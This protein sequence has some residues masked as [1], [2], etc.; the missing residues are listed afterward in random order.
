M[1]E[2][3]QNDNLRIWRKVCETDPKYLK[4][5]N[6]RGGFSAIC[7]QSQIKRA[8]E[9]WGPIGGWWGISDQKIVVVDGIVIYTASLFF[10]KVEVA[11]S[12]VEDTPDPVTFC[13]LPIASDHVFK[14]N[15]DSVKK[16]R[17][18]ALTKGLSWIGFNS[19]VF[20]GKFDDSKYVGKPSQGGTPPRKPAQAP[21]PSQPPQTP[22]AGSQQPPAGDDAD[23][24]FQCPKCGV[25]TVR[26]VNRKD[27]SGWFF[28]C[29]QFR[30][31]CKFICNHD[32]AGQYLEP[33][34]EQQ[35]PPPAQDEEQWPT[36][37]SI[38]F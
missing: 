14:P 26:K 9:L 2:N 6:A 19:D 10:P 36:D 34:A 22:P 31:G 8:T 32:G 27:G 4:H 7:A 25:G 35:S 28:G 15:E 5:V 1:E 3:E 38:P 16:V 37:D 12:A 24:T 18:D 29:S 33:A 11:G 17:T 20:E 13:T 21:Q 30:E 23:A